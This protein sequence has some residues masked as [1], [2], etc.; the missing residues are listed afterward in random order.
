MQQM[1]LQMI[2]YSWFWEE[3]RESLLCF[4]LLCLRACMHHDERVETCS[5][6]NERGRSGD[7][8]I[9]RWVLL[10]Q[11]I[12]LPLQLSTVQSCVR[13][14]TCNL[15]PV[16]CCCLFVSMGAASWGRRCWPSPI[17]ST[18]CQV[19][20]YYSPKNPSIAKKKTP[21]NILELRIVAT[22]N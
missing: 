17:I 11:S 16:I 19:S 6:T 21:S 3:E 20:C 22:G 4:A 2:M 18:L 10:H 12:G 9:W 5:D 8:R 14:G 1:L 13:S 15:Q 7:E